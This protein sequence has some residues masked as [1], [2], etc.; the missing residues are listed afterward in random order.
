MNFFFMVSGFVI[1]MTLE[2][3]KTPMDFIVSRVSRLYP[4]YWCAA[5]LTFVVTTAFELRGEERTVVDLLVNLTMLQSFVGIRPIDGVYW[6]LAC[7][8]IFYGLAFTTFVATRFK[9]IHFVLFAWL[10]LQAVSVVI[11]RYSGWFPWKVTLF[12]QLQYAHLFAAGILFYLVWKGQLFPGVHLLIGLCCANQWLIDPGN[13]AENAIVT[14]F[15]AVFALFASGN[16][17]WVGVRRVPWL[18]FI[19]PVSCAPEHRVRTDFGVAR[20]RGSCLPSDLR[21]YDR[22]PV[23]CHDHPR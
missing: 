12:L 15:F 18:N 17:G 1:Y 8:L 5:I 10:T 2:R 7:E 4:A 6:S 19:S 14:S 13:V 20:T 23:G 16:L 9:R 22:Q 11:E 3:T 21:S